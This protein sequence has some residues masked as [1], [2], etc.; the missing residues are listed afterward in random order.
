MSVEKLKFEKCWK[1]NCSPALEIYK[2]HI[3]WFGSN[4][5]ICDIDSF[6]DKKER[7]YQWAKQAKS[8][9]D[10]KFK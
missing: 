9:W 10:A 4:I 2:T 8:I 3:N 7:D 6:I 1:V 5:E